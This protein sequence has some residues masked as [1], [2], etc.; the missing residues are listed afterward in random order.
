MLKMC[1]FTY[2]WNTPKIVISENESKLQKQAN[3]IDAVEICSLSST[4]I[5]W[6]CILNSNYSWLYSLDL[7]VL[8]GYQFFYVKDKKTKNK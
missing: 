1:F 4:H 2:V 3:H 7:S 6:Y 8:S 5:V